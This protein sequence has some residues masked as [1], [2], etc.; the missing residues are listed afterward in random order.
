[1]YSGANPSFLHTCSVDLQSG[2][3]GFPVGEAEGD[4]LGANVGLS[5]GWADFDGSILGFVVGIADT[6]GL[7]EGSSVSEEGA[8][9]ILGSEEVDGA[10]EG[11]ALGLDEGCNDRADNIIGLFL[12]LG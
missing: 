9:D 11:V 4:E 7:W 10:I 6:D 3:Q 5:L 1:M 8:A 12:G 2:Y